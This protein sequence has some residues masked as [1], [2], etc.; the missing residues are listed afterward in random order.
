MIFK[1]DYAPFGHDRRGFNE[2]DIIDVSVDR[3]SIQRYLS[4]VLYIREVAILYSRV[5]F[6]PHCLLLAGDWSKCARESAQ[7]P[8][9]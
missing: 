3:V 5:V 9:P 7:E 1:Y 8:E 2:A 4:R 6:F